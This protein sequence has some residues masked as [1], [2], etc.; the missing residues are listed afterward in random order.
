MHLEGRVG[1]CLQQS[2]HETYEVQVEWIEGVLGWMETDHVEQG[3]VEL[4]GELLVDAMESSDLVQDAI[5]F[6]FV[7][8][9]FHQDPPWP[10]R[11]DTGVGQSEEKI[12]SIGLFASVSM[13]EGSILA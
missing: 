2:S 6:V 4:A 11:R 9:H 3:R 5:P 12:R 7:F 8:V 1:S 10:G 13:V